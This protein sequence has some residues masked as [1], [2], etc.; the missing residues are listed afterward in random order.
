MRV[1][2]VTIGAA[3]TQVTT[4]TSIYITSMLI[5]ASGTDY[6]GDST[7]SSNNGLPLTTTPVGF[8][9]NTIRGSQLSQYWVAGG[10]GDKVT[11]LYE[12]AE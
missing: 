6:L 5:R 9:V 2:T 8:S 1:L 4:N 12:T 7:V 10:N 3:A 11:I